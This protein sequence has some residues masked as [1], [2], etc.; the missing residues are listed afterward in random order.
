MP[1]SQPWRLQYTSFWPGRTQQLAWPGQLPAGCRPWTSTRNFPKRPGDGDNVHLTS[2]E[3]TGVNA[4]PGEL[5]KTAQY[6]E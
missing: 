5:P 6:T 4:L 3:L 2:A 1:G